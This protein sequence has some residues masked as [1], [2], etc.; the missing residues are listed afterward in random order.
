METVIDLYGTMAPEK[1]WT[2]LGYEWSCC[3]DIAIHTQ[4]LSKRFRQCKRL[5]LNMMGSD[6][7]ATYDSLRDKITIYRGCYDN[8]QNGM[9]WTLGREIALRF[10]TLHRYQQKGQP[11]LLTMTLPKS[12]CVYL[13][14]RDEQEIVT[15]PHYVWSV[16]SESIS[17]Q[18]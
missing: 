9:S 3:D 13:N 6:E 14:G 5:R 16:K 1:W 7:R 12:E 15:V 2:V 11:L 18:S 8:N 4:W 17:D 10:P